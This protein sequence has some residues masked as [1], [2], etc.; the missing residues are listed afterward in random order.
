MLLVAVPLAF[1]LASAPTPRDGGSLEAL[2]VALQRSRPALRSAGLELAPAVDDAALVAAIEPALGDSDEEVRRAAISALGRSPSQAA[3]NA[4]LALAEAASAQ[5][6]RHP[7]ELAELMR[8]LGRHAD[9]RC[10][11]ALTSDALA[12]LEPEPLRARILALGRIRTR[13]SVDALVALASALPFAEE[14]QVLHEL[15]LSFVALT[16]ETPGYTAKS[17][18]HWW[19]SRR[20]SF[21][22]SAEL[23]ALPPAL[24][25]RWRA[26]WADRPTR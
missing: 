7:R 8:A 18:A 20:T 12:S 23:P 5:L 26:A 11:R 14:Q 22:V 10:L 19:E 4:L 16:G 24:A 1:A 17:L 3:L 21:V 15:R 6:H 2:Q 9:P 25:R 13:E